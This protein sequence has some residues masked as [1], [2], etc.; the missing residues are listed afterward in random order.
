MSVHFSTSW[1]FQGWITH[2]ILIIYSQKVLTK[3]TCSHQQYLKDRRC[4]SKCGPGYYMFAECAGSS[5]TKCRPCGSDEYQPD[6]TN[7]TKCLPQKFCDTGKGFN[8]ERPNNPKTAVPCVCKLGLQC[9]PI[10]CE[11]CEKI[12][13]CGPGYG[14]EE[15]PES[16]RKMCVACNKGSFSP[17]TSG[18]PCNVWT[19]CKSLGKSEKQ[20]GSD[21]MDAVCGPPPPG[22]ASSWVLLCV[23]SVVMVLSLVI[24]LLFCYKNKLKILS[25]NL[26][27]CVQNLKRTRIQQDTLAPL[28]HSGREGSTVAGQNCPV[29]ESTC[30][31]G[32]A[33]NPSETL[34]T[35]P[36]A[37][38]VD[39]VKLPPTQQME[40]ERREDEDEGVGSEGSG[41]AEEVSEEGVSEGVS[42]LW[43]GS[44]MCVLSV[45]EPLE[46]GENEDCSQAVDP[47]TLGTCSCG[48][49]GETR[50]GDRV[51][52]DLQGKCSER[53]YDP[54]SPSSLVS[55]TVPSCDL[56][57][58]LP[59]ATDN[60]QVKGEELYRLNCSMSST[61][62]IEA[63][64]TSTST[65]FS[66][67]FGTPV[68][69]GDR[70]PEHNCGPDSGEPD[71]GISWRDSEGT[72]LSELVCTPGSLQ[73]QLTE[74]ALTSGQVTGNHNTT[75]ISSGQVM[76]FS[77]DVIV[78]Y[79]SQTSLGN[80]GEEPDDAFGRPV[81][82]QANERAP[83]FQSS[84]SSK[85]AGPSS[86]SSIGNSFTSNLL[87]Q[88]DN[89]PVQEV[90]DEWPSEK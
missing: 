4:C 24:L 37:V 23:L 33:H 10:N 15:H 66:E 20:P 1:I 45:R 50:E 9:S 65:S 48:G 79:V 13:T 68:A 43:A 7:E 87:Q 36:T 86:P 11:F 18:K 54:S 51:M 14:L 76:N 59:Q 30:L 8:R 74:Q 90:T 52:E 35:C 70:R 61:P 47:G 17:D 63:T 29:C 26:R 46:V 22:P 73:G 21:Q 40:Q 39:R 49:E 57:L 89:L 6:W 72:K 28:Y 25:V 32:L 42:P 55:P 80:D 81:Q 56:S 44:C 60:S 83:L 27:S 67:S 16:G 88:D 12:P 58:T 31:T 5:D 3:P 64:P 69:M 84:A 71:Q 75:F 34:H 19:N 77:A 41:E 85:S 53:R 38:H 78:V 82:E 2:L 62:I